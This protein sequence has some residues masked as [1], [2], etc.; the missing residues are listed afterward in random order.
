MRVRGATDRGNVH[1]SLPNHHNRSNRY[2]R[3]TCPSSANLHLDFIS[4]G[5]GHHPNQ[6]PQRNH[7]EFPAIGELARAAEDSRVPGSSQLS[8]NLAVR[9]G[10]AIFRNRSFTL[11][12]LCLMLPVAAWMAMQG[13][14]DRLLLNPIAIGVGLLLLII[15]ESIRLHV[16]AYA[17]SGTSG[18]TMNMKA[19]MLTTTG[20]YGHVR[21]PLYLGNFLTLVGLA[22]LTGQSFVVLFVAIVVY[23]QY[24]FVIRAEEAF[25][26]REHGESFR[27]FVASVPRFIPQWR[28]WKSGQ[29]PEPPRWKRAVLKE[30]DTIFG[31]FCASWGLLGIRLGL[32][33]ELAITQGAIIW[34]GLLGLAS[35]IWLMSKRV[36]K[37]ARRAQKASS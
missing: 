7:Q 3:F 6:L 8:A 24:Y 16:V 19:P 4:A 20:L 17:R 11:V 15:G 23:T 1:V 32:A 2:D 18:R 27:D 29:I 13:W 26:A 30:Q 10:N 35:G 31:I 12:P 37:A 5:C 22:C 28:G 9:F 36:K 34:L 14:T 25:L 33:N 21:N